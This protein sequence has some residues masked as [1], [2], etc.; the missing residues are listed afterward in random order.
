MPQQ[1]VLNQGGKCA[2]HAAVGN[3]P[4]G[5]KTRRGAVQHAQRRQNPLH[6]TRASGAH[7]GHRIL[8]TALR[9]VGGH[10]GFGRPGRLLKPSVLDRLAER[11]VLDAQFFGDFVPRPPSIEKPLRVG[12]DRRCQHRR[13]TPLAGSIEALDAFFTELLDVPFDAVLWNPKGPHDIDLLAGPFTHQLGREHAERSSIVLGME[14][15]RLDPTKVGPRPGFPHHT[16]K[17]AD[18]TGPLGDHR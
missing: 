18:P 14:K 10:R 2:E 11:I 13:T 4:T 3:V 1:S 12:G 6:G 9:L 16:D 5:F 7:L 15:N 8:A 17:I